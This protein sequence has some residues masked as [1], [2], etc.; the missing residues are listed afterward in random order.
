MA[1]KSEQSAS[2]DKAKGEKGVT[3]EQVGSGKDKDPK[4]KSATRD[5]APE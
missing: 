1:T 3:Q 4:S 2:G 5:P